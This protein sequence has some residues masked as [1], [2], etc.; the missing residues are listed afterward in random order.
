MKKQIKILFIVLGSIA[1]LF[2]IDL[3]CIFTINRPLFAIQNDGG[4]V[5]KGI[6][7][8]TYNCDEYSTPQIKLK[9]TKF[10]CSTAKVNIGKVI[11]ITDTTK[12]MKNFTCAEVMDGFY[13]DNNYTYY[14]NCAK[15]KYIIVKYE[16]GYEEGVKEA[17]KYGT[18]TI[19]DLDNY[20]IDYI[21]YEKDNEYELVSSLKKVDYASIEVLVKFNNNLYGKSNS[22][23]DYAYN[24]KQIGTIDKITLSKYIPR[25]NNETNTQEI[26]NAK[27]YENSKES[28]VLEYNNEYVLFEKLSE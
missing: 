3:I 23:I 4:Y 6:F 5:Y 25:L 17:L 22:V 20:N 15:S 24:A 26:L 21:K 2:L 8:D 19:Q 1:L 27:V 11:S 28:I 16:N 10:S 13:E 14:F 12:N 9:G 7:Y 18:I